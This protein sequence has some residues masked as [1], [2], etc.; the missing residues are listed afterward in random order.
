MDATQ[1]GRVGQPI[2]RVAIGGDL[3]PA[4]EIDRQLPLVDPAAFLGALQPLLARADLRVANLECPLTE[5]ALAAAK[6]GPALR[7]SPRCVEILRSGRIDVVTLAN[8]HAM[9]FGPSGLKDT[10]DTCRAAGIRTVG[11]GMNLAEASEPLVLRIGG[12]ALAIVNAVEHEFGGATATLAGVN[13]QDII[14]LHRQVRELRRTGHAVLVVL[15]GG[16]E[17]CRT[18]SPET[19]RR[20]R[21]IAEAGAAAVVA[22]HTHC[23]SGMEVHEGVPI[24]YGLGNLLFHWPQPRDPGWY[25]GVLLSLDISDGIARAWDITPFSQC[26]AGRLDVGLLEG[27]ERLRV[28]QQMNDVAESLASPERLEAAFESYCR[29]VEPL[30]YANLFAPVR[31][32]GRLFRYGWLRD[33]VARPRR[34][35]LLLNLMRC[36][37]HREACIRLLD[38]QRPASPSTRRT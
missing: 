27:E 8:N 31:G 35:R 7:A 16:H 30:Y 26:R 3:C 37:A 36:E 24:F 29:L 17:F 15:H 19:V 9:D 4:G 2:V 34:R 10:L 25:E 13:P 12:T 21:F 18:P 32:T 14:G 6:T 33:L 22:H 20:Y 38:D 1:A 5:A 23:V 11:A 28:E